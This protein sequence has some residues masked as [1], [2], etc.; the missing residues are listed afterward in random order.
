MMKRYFILLAVLS[1]SFSCACNKKAQEQAPEL[2]SVELLPA[3]LI[4]FTDHNNDFAFRLYAK[5]DEEG[6]NLF[7]SPY[8]ISTALS[9]AY[10]GAKNNTATE[11][12]KALCFELPEALHH[13]A[14][15]DLGNRLNELGKRGKAELNVANGLFGAKLYE[16]LLVP[17]YKTLLQDFYGSD[18]YSLDFDD[19]QGSAKYIN[20]WVLDRTNQRIKDLVS[21]DH[22]KQS[23]HG[24]VL[25]NAIFFKGKWL[26]QFDPKATK[27]ESFFTKPDRAAE[28]TK[29]VDLMYRQGKYGYARMPGCQVLELPYEEADLSMLMVLPDEQSADKTE[30]TPEAYKQWRGAIKP[31]EVKAI[32]PRFTLE[33]TLENVPRMMKSMGMIDAFSDVAADFTGIRKPGSADL[34]IMDIIH[35][36]FVEVKEEGTE[37]AAATAVVMATKSVPVFE[38]EIPVF[39]ADHPFNYM[40]I[41]KPS[42]A[43]LFLGKFA[44][45]PELD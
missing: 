11:M 33:L 44:V 3:E 23:N 32:I 22:I 39:R 17:E 14:F 7:F 37:A 29:P 10:G 36:A 42:G 15:K 26:L 9:M 31:Q 18:L 41:H 21:P 16:H 6:K 5:A 30:M 43:V 27:R 19:A 25:V 20:D 4:K 2:A 13:S 34:Y 1:L 8:S 45:P 12:A 40:I 35:K 38:D 28:N 24:I